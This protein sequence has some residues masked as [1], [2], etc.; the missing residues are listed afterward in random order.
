M[1]LLRY[2]LT[3][4]TPL[5][6]FV[7]IMYNVTNNLTGDLDSIVY[8]K[9]AEFIS[10]GLTDFMKLLSFFGS[11]QFLIIFSLVLVAVF[12]KYE[13]NSFNTAMIFINLFSSSV[14]N[15]SIKYLIRRDRPNILRLIEIIGYSFPSGHSM[16]S[17]SFYGFL[18]Y[19][20]FKNI[21]SR[22]KYVMAFVLTTVILLI[23]LSRI[24]LGVHYFSDVIGG[25]TLGILWIGIYTIIV[26]IRYNKKINK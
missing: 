13:R 15:T 2:A 7:Y 6:L 1:K 20:S 26:D 9:V 16:V 19:L 25:F 10:P 12:Y 4:A 17:M 24:Y 22:W 8:K 11:G 18:I 21:N 23:G 14:I 5:V 3:I